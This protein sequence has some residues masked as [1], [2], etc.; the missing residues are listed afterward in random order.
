MHTFDTPNSPLER[1][2]AAVSLG[3][4]AAGSALGC[5]VPKAFRRTKSKKEDVK[6]EDT[7]IILSDLLKNV[8]NWDDADIDRFVCSANSVNESAAD[9]Y[10]KHCTTHEDDYDP[11]LEAQL[12]A[13]DWKVQDNTAKRLGLLVGKRLAQ[14]PK[15]NGT[16]K[17]A[18]HRIHFSFVSG[19]LREKRFMV[20]ILLR[21]KNTKMVC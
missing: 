6:L 7:D 20:V 12:H 14:L 18:G 17:K 10:S 3:V 9:W 11:V 15:P 8:H 5:V 21:A 13:L 16:K 2:A 4:K 19:A 1:A